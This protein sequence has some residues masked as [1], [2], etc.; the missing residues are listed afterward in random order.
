MT[1]VLHLYHRPSDSR[2]GA[3]TVAEHVRALRRY[4]RFS[5]HEV[6]THFGMPPGLRDLEFDAIVLHYSLF[7]SVDYALDE[8]F[9]A[10]LNTRGRGSYTV[11][12]F[13]DEHRFC[14]RRFR[15]LNEFG[16]DCVYSCL[17]PQYLDAVYGRYTSVR[18][19]RSNVPGYAGEEM[20]AAARRLKRPEGDRPID[21]GY[22]GRS[23][24]IYSG[25][26]GREKYEIGVRFLARAAPLGLRLDIAG[27][28]ADRIY[29]DDWYR[30]VASCRAVL[31]TESG[32]SVFDLEGEVQAAHDQLLATGEEP[33][34]ERLGDVLA[35]WE[36]RIP[37]RTISPRHFE[38]AALDVCQILYEGHYSG[39]MEPMVHYIP[40]AKDFSNFD[41]AIERFRDPALRRELNANAHRDLIE[42]GAWS[43]EALVADVDE[44][45]A[46][47]GLDARTSAAETRRIERALARG[48]RARRARARLVELND[49]VRERDFPGKAGF[50]K[51]A[52]PVLNLIDRRLGR[53]A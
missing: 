23:L 14:Q 27:D 26:G 34:F 30:F 41:E 9:L 38:A 31:G 53:S 49:E 16:I 39:A 19:L 32:V 46:A 44:T 7:G 50:R 6:N 43:Y 25:R 2:A 21:I 52:R 29:G 51:V 1:A 22:R 45:L 18:T 3:T 28:E 17:E 35:R 4:S 5:V 40:L 11:A 42:S 13:Q 33:T 8:R 10:Y 24:P 12:F 48:A 20:L 47:A 36:D 37:Y 15:F